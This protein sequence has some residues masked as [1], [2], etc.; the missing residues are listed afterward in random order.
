VPVP[1]E[2]KLAAIESVWDHKA[3]RDATWL[4]HPVNR[5]PTDLH[6]Y[7]ELLAR[8]RLVVVVLVGEAGGLGGRALYVA[9]ICN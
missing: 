9:S 5:Y 3:W 7:Q 1:G 8:L 6:V 2:V 4:G